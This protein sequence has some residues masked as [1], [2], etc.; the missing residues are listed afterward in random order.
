MWPDQKTEMT[1]PLDTLASYVPTL[2]TRRLT[3][4]SEPIT[5]ETLER[6]QAVALFADISGFT[7][8]AE[9]LAQEGPEGAEE[10]SRLLNAY[11]GQLIDLITAH[12]GD[13][14]KFAGDAMLAIWPAFETDK[15]R[16]FS[17]ALLLPIA[18]LSAVQCGLTIQKA[19]QSFDARGAR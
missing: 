16:P 4:N 15:E 12:G 18:A 11:F 19:L 6:F 7:R 2:I 9:R 1:S 14:V 10:L 8:L 17:G 3:S 5:T 13:V